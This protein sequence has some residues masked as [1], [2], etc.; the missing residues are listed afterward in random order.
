MFTKLRFG[1]VGGGNGGNIGNSHRIGAQMDALAVLSAGCLTRNA[2]QNKADCERWGIPADR[3]YSNYKEMAEKESQRDDCIDFVTVVTPDNSHY[4][5]VKCFL[6]HGINVVC[7]KP[8]T[9][10]IAQ[11]EELREIAK[12]NGCEVCV[13]YTYAHYP[14]LRQC[15]KMIES[16]EI[17]K[18]VDMVV[19]Y[20]EQ[21]M[22]EALCGEGDGMEFAK[23]AGDPK[24]VGNSNV[25]ATM[26]THLYYMIVSMTGLKME[27]VLADFGHYPDDAPLENVN[28]FMFKLENGLRGLGW[29]SNI[30]IGHDCSM[31]LRIYGDKGSIEWSHLRPWELKYTKVNKPPQIYTNSRDYLYPAAKELS[32]LPSGH[33]EAH[34]EAFGNIYRGFCM[35][36]LAKKNGTDPGTFTFPD[37]ND[38]IR[39]IEFIDACC[40]SNENNNRWAKVGA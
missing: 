32:R 26:G 21:W 5:I 33:W 6:E 11:A 12:R 31:V 1:M 28:R 14:I 38:G 19:E 10:N 16:G 9:R 30:A 40:E 2:E 17:G 20:P 7:E 3:V 13:T 27:S 15:R 4:D 8:F 22:I 25:S 35:N 34:Y 39:G 37:I 36:L 23:W 24:K 18:L 29:T